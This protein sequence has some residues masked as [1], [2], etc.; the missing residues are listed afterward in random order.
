MSGR[1][2]N[3]LAAVCAVLSGMVFTTFAQTLGT[4]NGFSPYSVYGIGELHSPGTAH[5]QTL[6]GS[7]IAS[8]NNRYVNILNP[9]AI[10]AR[11]TLTA[12]FD[13]G[14]GGKMSVYTQGDS[15]SM[16]KVLNISDL[17]MSFPIYKNSAFMVGL[18]PFSDVGYDLTETDLSSSGSGNIAYTGL[19]TYSAAG[20][21]GTYQ[22]LVG[23]GATFFDRLSVGAQYIYYFGGLSKESSVAFAN[24]SF[25]GMYVGDTLQVR[26]HSAKFGLQYEQ[27]LGGKLKLTAGATYR[28]KA[29]VGGNSVNYTYGSIST[30]VQ[31]LSR[32]ESELEGV[33]FGDEIGV[34]LN[35]GSGDKWSLEVD[36]T[37]SDWSGSGFDSYAGLSARGASVF[38]SAVAQSFRGGFEITPNRN[39]IRY[40]MNKCTYRIGGYFDQSYYRVDGKSVNTAAITLGMTLPV[41]RWSNGITIGIEAGSRG[42][43][44]PVKEYFGAFTIGFNL[45][46]VWFLK[47]MYE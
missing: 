29:K 31:G 33:Y 9:A 18:V 24:T 12:M 42:F 34:G 16:G 23:A 45:Y 2:I 30:S 7:G 14:L 10:T 13:V 28:L 46:D 11:D 3:R 21:G 32:S 44:T 40:Y 20:N 37:R 25:Q 43:G 47:S 6:G 38:S 26:G 27:P 36:Y 17:V 41:F 39:D 1:L 22:L 4:D 19:R 5:N 8:R 35:L 15:R